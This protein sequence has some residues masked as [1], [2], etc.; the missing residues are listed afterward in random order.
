METIVMLSSFTM[1]PFGVLMAWFP[2]WQWTK[3]I[4]QS[5]LVLLGP[6]LL[7]TVLLLPRLTTV[8]AATFNPNLNGILSLFSTP[9]G[10]TLAW[11][12]FLAFDL[13]A[14]RWIYLD[15]YEHKLSMWLLLPILILT[16]MLGPCGLA[17]YILITNIP[18]LRPQAV[19]A[20]ELNPNILP[21]SP[22][23][24]N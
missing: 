9:E 12:Y 2:K 14:A 7:Y 16:L 22:S 6:S 19:R 15:N 8:M 5:P 18:K 11:V 17:L 20:V 4:V 10:A 21:S 24:S 13:L 23:K 1:V 3:R